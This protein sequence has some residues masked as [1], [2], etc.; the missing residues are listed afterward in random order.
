MQQPGQSLVK[1]SNNMY[2]AFFA[3][4]GSSAKPR[5]LQSGFK[6]YEFKKCRTSFSWN[7]TIQFSSDYTNKRRYKFEGKLIKTFNEQLSTQNTD[8]EEIL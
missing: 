7:E 2:F 6:T 4:D 8:D 3:S 5:L 1:H